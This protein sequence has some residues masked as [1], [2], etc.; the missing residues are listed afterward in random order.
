M[1]NDE[2][3]QARKAFKEIAGKAG[4]DKRGARWERDLRRALSNYGYL[5]SAMVGTITIT[6]RDGKAYSLGIKANDQNNDLEWLEQALENPQVAVEQF[7]ALG[8]LFGNN[9]AALA[10]TI[11]LYAAMGQPFEDGFKEGVGARAEATGD[12]TLT[13]TLYNIRDEIRSRNNNN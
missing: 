1:T 10:E 8:R 5:P 9:M 11:N 7:R 2:K 6:D 3:E 12:C 4:T 13:K